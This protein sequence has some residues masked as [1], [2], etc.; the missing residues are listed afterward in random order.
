MNGIIKKKKVNVLMHLFLSI[1]LLGFAY[2]IGDLK[3]WR[4]Y[5]SSIQYVIICNL[6]YNYFCHDYLLWE[7]K[8]D[9]LPK[10]HYIVDLVYTFVT[11]PC[12]T[13]LFLTHY[14]YLK[15]KIKQGKYILY[16]I[17]GSMMIEMPLIY[18]Q[19][20]LLKNG[21]EYWMDFLF[22]FVMFV[23]IRLH[24]THPIRSYLFSIVVI[25]FMLWYF[26]VPI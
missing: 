7:Y 24:F 23:F 5:L 2:W 26:H 10:K 9:I 18:Y 8:G 1:I 14:P 21:Y 16:W 25:L 22:Y 15:A 20:L 11:L 13:L 12:L 3:N 4:K 6:L 19:R 17:V